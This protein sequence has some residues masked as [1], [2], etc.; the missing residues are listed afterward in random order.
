MKSKIKVSSIVHNPPYQGGIMQY[1]VLLQNEMK[2]MV[3]FNL[4]GF[5]SLYPKI[6]YKGVQP[7]KNKHGIQFTVPCPRVLK[8]YSP[9][10][11]KKAYE[12]LKDGDVIHINWFTPQM[13]PLYYTVL[14]LNA[15][16]AK[17]PVVMTCHNIE[18]HETNPLDHLMTVKTFNLVNHFV[19]HAK[20]N[21]E[22]LINDYGKSEKNVHVIHHGTFG[23]FTNWS[24]E[25][26]KELKKF[27]HFKEDDIVL[28]FFG[29]IRYYKG[30]HHLLKAL[31]KIVE[32]NPNVKVLIGG[33]LWLGKKYID[34]IIKSNGMS[35]HVRVYPRYV[36]DYDVHK[37]FDV[38]DIM[39]L[40]YNNSEQT[41]SGPLFVGMAFGKPIVVSPVGGVPEFIKNK[42]NG[43][44]TPCGDEDSLAK[45]INMLIK[46]KKL[47]KTIGRNAKKTNDKF[48]WDKVAKQYFKVYKTAFE[49]N[50]NDA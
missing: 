12:M 15:M 46:D 18:P 36:Q 20:Q 22:R 34:D 32:E 45:N 35:K 31:P 29:Y 43:I 2:D 3:D 4:V 11:W 13:A 28:L 47:Q 41:I 6:I 1:S 38:S 10:S 33:E 49:D 39:V 17:K 7:K 19:V 25:S 23:Y 42:K 26:K 37:F 14:K 8:W 5:K 21:K 24:K 30:L 9:A 27:F 48:L 50:K 44:L 16:G 40:P